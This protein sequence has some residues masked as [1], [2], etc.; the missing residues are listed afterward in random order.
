MLPRRFK[1]LLHKKSCS[2]QAHHLINL[3]HINTLQRQQ[4]S[5]LIGDSVALQTE[6]DIIRGEKH[7]I[8]NRYTV[9]EHSYIIFKDRDSI[10]QVVSANNKTSL[11]KKKQYAYF[12]LCKS[13][14]FERFLFQNRHKF[15][16]ITAL[17]ETEKFSTLKTLL[18]EAIQN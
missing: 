3:S 5:P 10:L 7:E 1:G 12:L 2:D 16:H 6:G 14:G 15:D 17:G 13:L 4:V 18:L 8:P 9:K 11:R